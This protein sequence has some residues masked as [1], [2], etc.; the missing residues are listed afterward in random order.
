MSITRYSVIK[1]DSIPALV[2]HV[3]RLLPDGYRPLGGVAVV[4]DPRNPSM[5]PLVYVQAIWYEPP[6]GAFPVRA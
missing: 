5:Q 6:A 4:I 1:H 2:D 3:N